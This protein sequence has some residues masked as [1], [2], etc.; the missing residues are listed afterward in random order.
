M[1]CNS[2]TWR[3]SL[4]SRLRNTFRDAL[5]LLPKLGLVKKPSFHADGISFVLPMK[6]EERWIRVSIASAED[7]A[8]EIIV[9][10]SH[11]QRLIQRDT[12]RNYHTKHNN[13]CVYQFKS[14]V[15]HPPFHS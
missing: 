3:T 1:R 4:P 15:N 5:A 14:K 6:D 11:F 2:Q 12:K 13:N 10:D 8:D 9:V 7:V